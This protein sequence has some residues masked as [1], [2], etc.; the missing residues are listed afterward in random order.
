MSHPGEVT[1]VRKVA[2]VVWRR[3]SAI[4]TSGWF[5]CKRSM[6]LNTSL[7]VG[8]QGCC[9]MVDPSHSFLPCHQLPAVRGVAGWSARR[10]RSAMPPATCC[11][12]CCRLVSPSRSLC[13]AASRAV[14]PLRPLCHA[15]SHAVALSVARCQVHCGSVGISDLPVDLTVAGSAFDVRPTWR[16]CDV[17]KRRDRGGGVVLWSL[18]AK[19]NAQIFLPLLCL[20]VQD[21]EVEKDPVSFARTG[22]GRLLRFDGVGLGAQVRSVQG[23]DSRVRIE[24][25][26]CFQGGDVIETNEM[27]TEGGDCPSLYQSARYGDFCYKF[28]SL[29]P[30]DY[31]VD[32]HFAE[33]VNTNGP[34]GIRVFN[35]FV[36]EEK[37]RYKSLTFNIILQRCVVSERFLSVLELQILSG[38]DIYSVVG[39]NK[40]LQL[41]DLRVSVVD[42]GNLLVSFEGLSGTPTVSGICIRKAPPLSDL[43]KPEHLTCSKCATEIEVSPLKVREQRFH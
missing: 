5:L 21:S 39:A 16:H 34:K 38:L 15:A 20:R 14:G 35:V 43:V 41:V 23:Q 3:D 40:P 11:Q 24:G 4:P 28:D 37:A 30:G 33:I 18:A 6:L 9:R 1:R 13:H 32:L 42:D 27:I 26:S 29:V 22:D 31:F 17:A 8:C 36:Q 10:V 19:P 12:G 25:D 2:S 7:V